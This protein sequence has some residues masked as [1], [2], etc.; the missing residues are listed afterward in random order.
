[1][2][3][4][5]DPAIL[6]I[7]RHH[8]GE[9]RSIGSKERL[10]RALQLRDQGELGLGVVSR[11]SRLLLLIKIVVPSLVEVGV[12]QQSAKPRWRFLPLC[13][14]DCG[15]RRCLGQREHE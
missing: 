14:I 15:G 5:E 7:H 4:S 1:V 13:S 3:G 11:R 10:D 12:G 9:R 6:R 8:L 2:N